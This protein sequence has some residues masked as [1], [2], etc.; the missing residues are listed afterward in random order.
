MR[1]LVALK[2]DKLAFSDDTFDA[3]V[4]REDD[5]D[6]VI[7]VNLETLWLTHARSTQM[8]RC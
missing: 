1:P 2:V 4:L 3:L 8:R 6:G 5:A 7:C